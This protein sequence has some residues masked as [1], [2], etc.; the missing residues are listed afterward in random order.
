MKVTIEGTKAELMELLAEIRRRDKEYITVPSPY[1]V[2]P[3][4]PTYSPYVT[5]VVPYWETT[6]TSGTKGESHD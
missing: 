4:Y 2:T 6:A 1:Y 3:T 5:K